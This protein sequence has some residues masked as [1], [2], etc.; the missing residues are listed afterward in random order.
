[1]SALLWQVLGKMPDKTYNFTRDKSNKLLPLSLPE[2]TPASVT[3]A[4]HRVLKLPS[5]CSKRFLTTKVDRHVT[6]V[7][8]RCDGRSPCSH[9]DHHCYC[10]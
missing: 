9:P 6:G 4:L 3:E 8:G 7:G 2:A 1:M 5:V 10:Q